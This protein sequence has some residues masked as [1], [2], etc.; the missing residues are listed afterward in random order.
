MRIAVFSDVHGNLTALQAVLNHIDKQ[1]DIDHIVFAGDLCLFG[2]RPQA[3]L[4]LIRNRNLTS[5]IGNTDEWILQ[6]PP[7]SEQAT[8]EERKQ[9]ELLRARCKWTYQSLDLSAGDWLDD[10]RNSFELRYVPDPAKNEDLL[11]VHANPVDLYQL[12]FPSEEKQ[13]M[14]YGSIRQPDS[15]LEPLFLD[16]EASVVALGHLH[17]PGERKWGRIKLV[18]ISSVSMPGD[19]DGRAKYVVFTWHPETGWTSERFYIDYPIEDE[20]HSFYDQQPPGWEK[21]IEQLRTLGYYPQIV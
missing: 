6:A 9:R 7:I 15:A 8:L 18:N 17:V 1:K 19:R 20:I 12:V 11:I 10:L 16:V 3:C 13:L 4:D 14:L 2:P 5:I 21:Q